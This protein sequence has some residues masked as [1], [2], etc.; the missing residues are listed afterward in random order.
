MT[1]NSILKD[2]VEKEEKEE[3]VLVRLSPSMSRCSVSSR[4]VV[5]LESYERLY[6]SLMRVMLTA[7]FLNATAGRTA[8]R[9]DKAT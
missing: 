7:G 1:F 4:R 5:K 9:R 3:C 8:C 6:K 2:V